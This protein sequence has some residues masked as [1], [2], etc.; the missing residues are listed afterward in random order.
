MATGANTLLISELNK[1]KKSDLIDILVSGKLPPSLS[2]NTILNEFIG[3][4]FTSNNIL[5][6]NNID[7]DHDCGNNVVAFDCEN[8]KCVHVKCENSFLK[9]E[10]SSLKHHNFHLEKRVSDQEEINNLLKLQYLKHSKPTSTSTNTNNNLTKNVLKKQTVDND[11]KPQ[12]STSNIYKHQTD[13]AKF[14]EI[15]VAQASDKQQII[16]KSSTKYL[17]GTNANSKKIQ[18]VEKFAYIYVGHIKGEVKEETL[19]E[20]LNENWPKLQ[21][22]I[23][24][25]VNKGNNSSFKIGVSS[26]NKNLVF[27]ADKW[28]EGVII[29]DYVFF[30]KPTEETVQ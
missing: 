19:T 15:P 14:K 21:L 13:N 18:G 22:Q 25:L 16:T 4:K 24:K 5:N 9:R 23:K 27:D 3:L 26:Q 10:I 2:N 6:G 7:D 11:S 8:L 20:F 29:K 1:L 17:K 12:G 28:P 30:R